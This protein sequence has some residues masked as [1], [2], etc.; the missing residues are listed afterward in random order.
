MLFEALCWN[1][2]KICESCVKRKCFLGEQS[3]GNHQGE[4]KSCAKPPPIIRTDC[5]QVL[6]AAPLVTDETP[7]PIRTAARGVGSHSMAAR[8]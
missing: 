6:Q 5:L 2:S 4:S 3:S 1:S 7:G 8:M